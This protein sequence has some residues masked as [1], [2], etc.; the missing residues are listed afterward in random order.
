MAGPLK[1]NC[2]CR[3]CGVQ[4]ILVFHEWP[5]DRPEVTF[6][7]HHAEIDGVRK[8]PCSV[9]A[10]DRSTATHWYEED[11]GRPAAA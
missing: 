8:A 1:P 5:S 10:P 6:E 3:V 2:A 7:Y 11:A 9:I 4:T